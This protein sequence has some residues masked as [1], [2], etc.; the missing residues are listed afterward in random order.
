MSD[1]STTRT[2]IAIASRIASRGFPASGSGD[3]SCAGLVIRL[4][5]SRGF[6]RRRDRDAGSRIRLT[7]VNR[8]WGGPAAP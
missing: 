8:R 2:N 1:V 7:Q 4:P 6:Y 3:S 5:L